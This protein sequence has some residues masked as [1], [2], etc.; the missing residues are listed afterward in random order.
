VEP[1]DDVILYCGGG[2]SASLAFAAL[3]SAGYER[4]RVYDGSWSEWSADPA[5]PREPHA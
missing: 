1:G 4:L 2:I 5:T 3:E